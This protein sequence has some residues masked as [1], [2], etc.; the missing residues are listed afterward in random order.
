[1]RY[2][3]LISFVLIG[4]GQTPREEAVQASSGVNSQEQEKAGGDD[5][6]S[7]DPNKLVE[8]TIEEVRGIAGTTWGTEKATAAKIE[9]D[10]SR[11]KEFGSGKWVVSAVYKG[12][13]EDDIE[14]ERKFEV[15]W[16]VHRGQLYPASTLPVN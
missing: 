4:C 6:I 13:N 5:A 2:V 16:K 3:L 8:M 14:I 12:M 10:T 1:M 11:I 9:T 15:T 7:V